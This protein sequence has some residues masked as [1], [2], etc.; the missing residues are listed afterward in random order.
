M[1][2]LVAG[3]LL[4]SG[5]WRFYMEY[6]KPYDGPETIWET[7]V[8]ILD[9]LAPQPSELDHRDLEFN[10]FKRIADIDYAEHPRQVFDLYVPTD[11]TNS[12][13]LVVFIHGSGLARATKGDTPNDWA[14][15]L[16]RKGIAVAQIEY[17]PF[18][19][20]KIEFKYPAQIDDCKSAIRYISKNSA[21]YGIDGSRI[22]LMGESFGGHLAATVGMISN[23]DVFDVPLRGTCVINGMTDFMSYKDEA[24][25]HRQSLGIAWPALDATTSGYVE[26]MREEDPDAPRMASAVTHVH[27]AASPF[28][29]IYGFTDPVIPPQQGN[30]LFTKLRNAGVDVE[31]SIV[32]GAGHGGP[33]LCNSSTRHSVVQF[34]TKILH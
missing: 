6:T 30:R 15:P 23:T 14:V 3:A 19:S 31:L 17:R 25:H 16:L 32:P 29:L 22:G 20:T 9:E 28:L 11:G 1:V 18:K 27:A 13:P 12:Y 24:A 4:A 21:N 34:F 8:A 33:V 7:K 5:G 2:G 26:P 10:A